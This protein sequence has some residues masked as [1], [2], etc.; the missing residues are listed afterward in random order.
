LAS[1]VHEGSE[2]LWNCRSRIDDGSTPEFALSENLEIYTSY[3][4]EVV[5]ASLE[6]RPEGWISIRVRNNNLTGC[7]NN[8]ETSAKVSLYKS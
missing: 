5:A 1:E 4:T 2:L 8:L 3:N 7:E 6:G